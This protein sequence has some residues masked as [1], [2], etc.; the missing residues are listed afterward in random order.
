MKC[1]AIE[2]HR[3]ISLQSSFLKSE[4]SSGLIK[5][6]SPSSH[7]SYRWGDAT[8]EAATTLGNTL[9]AAGPMTLTGV[10]APLQWDVQTLSSDWNLQEPPRLEHLYGTLSS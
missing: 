4:S 10:V 2:S 7:V 8:L 1:I 6:Y 5:Q 3:V 9:S